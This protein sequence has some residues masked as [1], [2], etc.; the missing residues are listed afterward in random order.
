VGVD[1]VNN[2]SKFRA[3]NISKTRFGKMHILLILCTKIS[4]DQTRIG[5]SF[6]TQDKAPS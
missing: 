6:Q 4:Q 5:K 3:N 2:N 1:T